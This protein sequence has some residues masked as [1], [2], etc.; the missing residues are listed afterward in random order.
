LG[1]WDA[2][3][4]CVAILALRAALKRAFAA[5]RAAMLRMPRGASGQAG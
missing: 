5:E 2:L 3:L 1:G 4:R